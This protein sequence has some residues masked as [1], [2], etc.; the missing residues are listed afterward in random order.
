MLKSDYEIVTQISL[1]LDS[2]ID[3]IINNFIQEAEKVP[4]SDGCQ[5]V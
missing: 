2:C 4:N 1:L 5:R 3:N